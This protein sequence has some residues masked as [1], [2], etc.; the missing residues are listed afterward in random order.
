MCSSSSSS[1]F[2][3]LRQDRGMGRNGASPNSG[4]GICCTGN[5]WVTPYLLTF[6]ATTVAQDLFRVFRVW[7]L[8]Q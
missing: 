2:A 4:C 8:R 3:A 6:A 7:P 5:L 1:A